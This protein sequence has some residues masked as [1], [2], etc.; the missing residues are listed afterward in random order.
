LTELVEYVYVSN[1]WLIY[2]IKKF[3]YDALYVLFDIMG[4]ELMSL[5]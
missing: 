5:V 4:L 1:D 3:K 2:L